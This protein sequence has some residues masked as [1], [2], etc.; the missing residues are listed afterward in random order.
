MFL[1]AKIKWDNK[2][3]ISCGCGFE[4]I[5]S[6]RLPRLNCQLQEK[7]L[8]IHDNL[9]I[10]WTIMLHERQCRYKVWHNVMWHFTIGQFKVQTIFSFNRLLRHEIISSFSSNPSRKVA[11]S[12][13]EKTCFIK[14]DI[15]FNLCPSPSL[16]WI[17]QVNGDV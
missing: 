17:D 9:V 16:N 8:K 6:L 5:R 11:L 14:N 3:N 12:F 10:W 13:G 4:S 15:S 2:L 7:H 1:H